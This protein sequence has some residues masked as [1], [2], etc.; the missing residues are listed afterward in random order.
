MLAC[1]CLEDNN[2]M[3]KRISIL[4]QG[5]QN[6]SAVNEDN[7]GQSHTPSATSLPLETKI[8]ASAG[9]EFLH[10]SHLSLKN[11]YI[12][13][14]KLKFSILCVCIYVCTHIYIYIYTHMKNLKENKYK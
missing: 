1:V 12:N 4:P 9:L 10:T 5:K 11:K 8:W 6:L 2:L 7:T 3:L 14:L 13:K